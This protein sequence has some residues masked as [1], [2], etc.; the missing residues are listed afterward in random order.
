M[1]FLTIR[2]I[3]KSS[4]PYNMVVVLGIES[5]AH[6]IGFSIVKNDDVLS[7]E[8]KLFHTDSGGMIP[9]QVA[10]HHIKLF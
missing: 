1:F 4:S 8:K 10:D 6:T 7:N 2:V 9:A 5:T 3:N